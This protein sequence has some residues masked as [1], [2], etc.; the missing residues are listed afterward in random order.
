MCPRMNDWSLPT[1]R[2]CI[3]TEKFYSTYR[4]GKV[5]TLINRKLEIWENIWIN[6]IIGGTN[7][8]YF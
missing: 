7:L 5:E 8:N 1:D 4:S 6:P 2:N 3:V